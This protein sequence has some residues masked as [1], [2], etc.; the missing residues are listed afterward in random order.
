MWIFKWFLTAYIYSLPLEAIHHVWDYMMVVGGLG[1]VYF[2]VSLVKSLE[3]HLKVLR[4]DTE[5]MRFFTSLREPE[6]FHSLVN[7][8]CVLLNAY[9]IRL[10]DEEIERISKQIREV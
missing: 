1:L 9:T 5:V 8:P 2:A 7:L 10:E 3:S 6:V 4:E